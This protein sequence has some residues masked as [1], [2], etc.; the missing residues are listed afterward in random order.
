MSFRHWRRNRLG[1]SGFRQ[2][3]SVKGPRPAGNRV[4]PAGKEQD[5][6][7]ERGEDRA[8]DE[9]GRGADL[10]PQETGDQA[11]QQQGYAAREVEHAE[12]GCP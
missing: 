7:A 4:G 2:D 12:G 3:V 8:D 10:L 11:R 9:G 1:A 6:E 5:G